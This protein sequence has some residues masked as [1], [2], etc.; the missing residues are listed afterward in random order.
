MGTG[1]M[2]NSNSLTAWLLAG[3]GHDLAVVEPPTGG[4]A[5]GWSAGLALAVHPGAQT[6]DC[7]RSAA[8]V[9][10]LVRAE[11]GDGH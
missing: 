4:R 1:E 9:R 7:A 5:P 2:W 10:A 6:R 11:A 3:S 8:T